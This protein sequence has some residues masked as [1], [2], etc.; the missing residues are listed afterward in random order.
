MRRNRV[1]ESRPLEVASDSGDGDGGPGEV[2]SWVEQRRAPTGTGH[3]AIALET[4]GA[5]DGG[6]EAQPE[7]DGRF[8][9][10]A[11]QPEVTAIRV[12]SSYPLD[13]AEFQYS[14]CCLRRAAEE[15]PDQSGQQG[16]E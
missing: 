5:F 11:G 3:P 13:T 2:A 7:A 6:V 16:W 12:E 10:L 8:A 14:E 15:S 9:I 1:V 4:A